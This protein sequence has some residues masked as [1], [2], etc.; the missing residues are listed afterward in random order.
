MLLTQYTYIKQRSQFGKQCI[1]KLEDRIAVENI[2]PE[3]HLM[4][5]YIYVTH[6]D[7]EVQMAPQL[8]AHEVQTIRK[9]TT[10]T[11]M[12]HEEG[13]WPKEV[14]YKDVEITQRYRRRVEKDDIWAPCM[15]ELLSTMEHCVLENNTMNIYENFFDD[16]VPTRMAKEYNL[17]VINLFED[18]ETKTRPIRHLSWSPNNSDRLAAAYA[19]YEFETQG[20]DLSPYSY[21]WDIENPN[22][23]LYTLRSQIPLMTVEFNPRDYVVL[24][25]GLMNG[26]VCYWDLRTGETPVGISHVYVSHRDPVI[27]VFW[28]PS[29]NSTDFFSAST[30]GLVLWWDIRFPKK[31]TE[32]LVMDLDDPKRGD[33][34]KAT[35]ITCLQ[36][37]QTMSSRFLVGTENGIVVNVNRRTENPVEKLLVRFECYEG[38]VLAIDR[39]PVYPKNFLTVGNWSAK[40][41]ADDT[42]EGNLFSIRQQTVDLTGGCWSKSRCSVFFTINAEGLLEV[43]DILLGTEK[44]LLNIRLCFDKLTAISSHDDGDILAVGSQKGNIYLLEC[45]EDLTVITKEDRIS[46]NN[47]LDR[48]GKYEKAIDSRLKEIRL[49]YHEIDDTHV[50]NAKKPRKRETKK[51][52][53]YLEKEKNKEKEKDKEKNKE[54]RKSRISKVR[55]SI[56]KISIPELIKAETDYYFAVNEISKKFEPLDEEDVEAAQPLLI[57]RTTVLRPEEEE[58]VEKEDAKKVRSVRRIRSRPKVERPV[59]KIVEKPEVEEE[60]KLELELEKKKKERKI[61]PKKILKKICL[62]PC[63][64][65][66]CCADM[67]EKLKQ[68][69]EEKRKEEE[70]LKEDAIDRTS[71]FMIDNKWYK[72]LTDYI[73]QIPPPTRAFKRKI[74]MMKNAPPYVLHKELTKAKKE[75]RDWQER[76]IAKKLSTWTVQQKLLAPPVKVLKE[77][78]DEDEKSIKSD[79]LREKEP[80]YIAKRT[81]EKKVRPSKKLEPTKEE[82]EEKKKQE[83]MEMWNLMK[84]KVSKFDVMKKWFYPRISAILVQEMKKAAEEKPKE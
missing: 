41:W 67:E 22:K 17:R 18:P 5:D 4:E 42:K 60:E 83:Q 24:V 1:F 33:I 34:Y 72:R 32:K 57:D 37:E 73:I 9:S 44:P 36:F 2:L 29:K 14:N 35:G 50:Q 11:G 53:K 77:V 54:K 21:V 76:A 65:E 45:T 40:L 8:A 70:R 3:P 58:E 84:Q 79:D 80:S 30:D 15:N 27:Q 68:K 39:N 74:L 20:T 71:P 23:A 19:Y 7:A 55:K 49:T 63:I 6:N 78:L 10:N 61:R 26:Q 48:C 81:V 28:I 62:E 82:L 46:L 56:P 47:Y 13:G 52:E 75:L 25:S 43:Y 12:Y 16:L 31:P 64:P 59:K 66:I 38:P 69:L 51:K